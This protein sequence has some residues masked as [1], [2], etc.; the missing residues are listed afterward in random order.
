MAHSGWWVRAVLLAA[1]PGVVAACRTRD[2]G[3]S[4]AAAISDSITSSTAPAIPTARDPRERAALAAAIDGDREFA[5]RLFARVASRPDNL[6][7]SP[8]SIR[9]ALA[10]AYAG[11]AGETRAQMGHVLSLDDRGLDGFRWLVASSMLDDAPQVADR[12]WGRRGTAFLPDFL[13]RMRDDFAAPLESLDF[14]GDPE[15]SRHTINAWVAKRTEQRIQDLLPP[16]AVTP[17]TRL[18]VTNAVYFR[19]RWSETF[20]KKETRTEAFVTA[21]GTTEEV[22]MMHLEHSFEHTTLNIGGVPCAALELGYKGFRGR[23]IVVLPDARDGLSALEARIDRRFFKELTPKFQTKTVDLA[24]PR[25]RIGHRLDLTPDLVA[26]GMPL[27]FTPGSADFTGMDGARDISIG[28]VIH[29]AFIAVDEEGTE[30]AA[31]TG[32]I[33]VGAMAPPPERVFFHADHPFL[34]AIVDDRTVLF[35]GHVLAP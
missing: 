35:V 15:G 6:V 17:D 20:S 10:M 14:A 32:A 11:A 22:P 30:A 24:I 13:D 16:G 31:A 29:Q 33:L 25:F 21:N 19:A 4:G 3:N 18:L 28:S 12:L 1:A 34:F 2:S 5:S 8:A 27:A 23:M 9:L 26:M 7:L